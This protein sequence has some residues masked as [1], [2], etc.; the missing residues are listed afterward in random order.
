[1][2]CAYSWL[3][4]YPVELFTSSVR[5]TAASFIFNATRLVAWIFPIAA[6]TMIQ[7]FGEIRQAVMML[8]SI[9]LLGLIIPFFLP[10]TRGKPLPR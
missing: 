4:I 6:G 7:F 8:G 3:A 5:S 2:G 9:Y 1:L 10:E